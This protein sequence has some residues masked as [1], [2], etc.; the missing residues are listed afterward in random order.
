MNS[1]FNFCSLLLT[2]PLPCISDVSAP[3]GSVRG[4]AEE[5]ERFVPVKPEVQVGPGQQN[6]DPRAQRTYAEELRREP[7]ADRYVGKSCFS[8][9]HD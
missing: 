7:I 9:M 3:V 8:F 5:P 2:L 4:A 1:V 6:H